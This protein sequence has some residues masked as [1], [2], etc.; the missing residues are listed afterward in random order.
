MST[1]SPEMIQR[2]FSCWAESS[3]SVSVI[4][5]ILASIS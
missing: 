1:V 3:L 4:L 5:A 2:T